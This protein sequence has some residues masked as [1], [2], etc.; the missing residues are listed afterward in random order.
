M[1]KQLASLIVTLLIFPTAAVSAEAVSDKVTEPQ[2]AVTASQPES[3]AS[4]NSK[5]TEITA[6][7]QTAHEKT[8]HEKIEAVKTPAAD[9]AVEPIT[10][11]FGIPLGEQFETSM[12]AKV[13]GRQEQVYNGQ[14]GIKLTG[15]LL[16]IEPSQPDGRFQQYSIKTTNDGLIYAI[17]GD[18]QYK[19]EPDEAKPAEAKQDESKPKGSGKGASKPGN[20]QPATAMQ[21]TCKA[22][23]KTMAGELESRYGKPRGQGW[24]GLW[25]T[26]RQPSDTSNKGLKLYG[27]RCRTGMYSIVYTDEI[28]RRGAPPVKAGSS[29]ETGAPATSSA[30]AKSEPGAEPAVKSETESGKKP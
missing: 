4:E 14:G 1:N 21:K 13:L 5:A 9:K 27:H 22:A 25:F 7:E 11:A 23:V 8:A 12:V 18:Y 30:P 2:T 29:A 20:R 17:Q 28:A 10:G 3:A 24:D 16:R 6:P 19:V 15:E 26:F